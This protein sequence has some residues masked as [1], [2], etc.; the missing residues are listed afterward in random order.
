VIG[1]LLDNAEGGNKG[2][3]PG[4]FK[5]QVVCKSEALAVANCAEM[6][7]KHIEAEHEEE[8]RERAALFNPPKNG[9]PN[10]SGA[11]QDWGDA[12]LR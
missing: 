8:R 9:Y 2:C 4:R 12:N 11:P 6:V 7:K 5:R 10:V 1:E 3:N